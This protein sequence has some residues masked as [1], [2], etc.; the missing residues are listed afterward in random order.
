MR[1]TFILIMDVSH[2]EIESVLVTFFKSQK[3]EV[4]TG[5]LPINSKIQNN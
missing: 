3:F 5:G 2:F 4:F 1:S